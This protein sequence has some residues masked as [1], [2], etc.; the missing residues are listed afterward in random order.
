MTTLLLLFLFCTPI[1]GLSSTHAAAPARAPAGSPIPCQFPILVDAPAHSLYHLCRGSNL[2]I[3]GGPEGSKGAAMRLRDGLRVWLSAQVQLRPRTM[4]GLERTA[5]RWEIY[6]GADRELETFTPEDI[7]A[8]LVAYREHHAASTTNHERALLAWFFHSPECKDARD[9][10][11]TGDP[12]LGSPVY[13][14]ERR[15]P[16]CLTSQEIQMLL[17]AAAGDGELHAIIVVALETGLRRHTVREL[18]WEWL[19]QDGWLTIPGEVMKCHRTLR[20]PLSAR[21]LAV[22]RDRQSAL[23][24]RMFQIGR[25]NLSKRF[26]RLCLRTHIDC[27]FHDL[28]RTFFTLMRRRGAPL[29]VCMAL[30]GHLDVRT[31]LKHY[32]ALS[33]EELLRAV[34]RSDARSESLEL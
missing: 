4:Y 13:P 5:I 12:L 19:S 30:S 20:I 10:V 15:E 16:R 7:R 11:L 22:L 25:S 17:T 18:R 29:E 27:T 32:R 24:G 31:A 21:A 23:S 34:G 28:R 14:E 26:H 1:C 6:F 9:G 33:P 8:Y 3:L 2:K